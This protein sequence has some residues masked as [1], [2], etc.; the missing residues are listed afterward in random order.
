MIN[1]TIKIHPQMINLP[2]MDFPYK[3]WYGVN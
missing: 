1:Q 3:A 2:W